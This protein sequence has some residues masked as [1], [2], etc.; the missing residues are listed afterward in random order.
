[1]CQ[2]VYTMDLQAPKFISGAGGGGGGGGVGTFD[3]S[4][5]FIN[6]ITIILLFYILY[7]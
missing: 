2:C 5:G 7:M 1:M 4:F 3:S 6:R